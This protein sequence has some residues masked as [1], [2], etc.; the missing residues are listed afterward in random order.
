MGLKTHPDIC[1]FHGPDVAVG[2]TP[3]APWPVR[4]G[5]GSL[6]T[7]LPPHQRA[8]ETCADFKDPGRGAPGPCLIRSL[9]SA[10]SPWALAGKRRRPPAQR[11]ASP[12]CSRLPSASGTGPVDAAPNALSCPREQRGLGTACASVRRNLGVSPELRWCPAR[13][14]LHARERWARPATRGRGG[15]LPAG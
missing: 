10:E 3:T 1:H 8:A 11:R 13:S 12:T 4:S 6:R 2:R 5:G 14:T 7:C 15:R 9:A